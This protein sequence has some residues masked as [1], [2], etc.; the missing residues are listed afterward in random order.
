MMAKDS[1]I[2][3]PSVDGGK[4]FGVAV[5]DSVPQSDGTHL[6]EVVTEGYL[7]RRV[8]VKLTRAQATILRDKLRHLQDTGAKTA[9]GRFVSNWT[10]AVQWI[11]EN[12]VN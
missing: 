7:P 8:D 11:I 4:A 12:E 6:V 3:L 5:S 9:E 2:S 10:Q 1:K